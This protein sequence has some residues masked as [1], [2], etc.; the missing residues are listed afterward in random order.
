MRQDSLKG[1]TSFQFPR[2]IS[3]IEK[4]IADEEKNS[5]RNETEHK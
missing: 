2:V 5:Q 3:R 1:Q 4:S